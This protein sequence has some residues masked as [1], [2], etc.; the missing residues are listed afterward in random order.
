MKKLIFNLLLL[1]PMLAAA[2]GR[3]PSQELTFEKDPWHPGSWRVKKESC[4]FEQDPWHPG[5]FRLNETERA[6][7]AE[8]LKIATARYLQ[9]QA[10]NEQAEKEKQQQEQETHRQEREKLLQKNKKDREALV[11]W[12][13]IAMLRGK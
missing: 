1:T 10:M 7:S 13:N 11:D 3:C 2:M 6:R 4:L 5:R 8:L 9:V 12:L